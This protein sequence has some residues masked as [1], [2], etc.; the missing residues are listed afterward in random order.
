MFVRPHVTFHL[1][2]T[3]TCIHHANLYTCVH[4]LRYGIHIRQRL[5][6][7]IN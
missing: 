4:I 1:L 5:K 2:D 6:Q 3:H 7:E